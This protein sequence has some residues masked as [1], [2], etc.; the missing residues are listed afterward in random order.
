MK[1]KQIALPFLLAALLFAALAAHAALPA[2]TAA[3]DF[4]LPTTKDSSLSLTQFRGQVVIL[5]FW[6]SN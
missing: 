4:T 3:P 6:K 2:G 5:A 1:R